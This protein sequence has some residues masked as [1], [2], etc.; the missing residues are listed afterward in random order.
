M[1]LDTCFIYQAENS[2]SCTQL[3]VTT[4][5]YGDKCTVFPLK[6]ANKIFKCTGDIKNE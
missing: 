1:L 3:T 2:F 5:K 4:N 6:H